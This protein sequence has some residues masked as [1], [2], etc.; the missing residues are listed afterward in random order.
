MLSGCI[1]AIFAI[2]AKL[3][4]FLM[5]LCYMLSLVNLL[6]QIACQYIITTV[7]LDCRL[8]EVHVTFT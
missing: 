2:V 6:L 5:L 4:E 3:A 1:L 7:K 8:I